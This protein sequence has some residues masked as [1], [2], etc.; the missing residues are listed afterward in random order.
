MLFNFGASSKSSSLH[1]VSHD[2]AT[3][4]MCCLST[5]E[6]LY[7]GQFNLEA[8]ILPSNRGEGEVVV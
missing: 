5:C 7:M 8:I 2:N 1:K 6:F 4:Y 3:L